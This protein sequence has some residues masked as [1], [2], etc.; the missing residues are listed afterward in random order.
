MSGR[1]ENA[2]APPRGWALTNTTAPAIVIQTGDG[3]T[4]L[5]FL[6][7]R[8]DEVEALIAARRATPLS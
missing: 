6:N 4:R 5:D 3:R 7:P 1:A 8:L 2:V